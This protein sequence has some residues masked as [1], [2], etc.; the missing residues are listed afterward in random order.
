VSTATQS[1]AVKR[2]LRLDTERRWVACTSA[3]AGRYAPRPPRLIP[4]ELARN[5]AAMGAEDARDPGRTAPLE[6]EHVQ[7]VSRGS[8]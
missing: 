8:G 2:T 6:L 3:N 1:D 5:G 7:R 4:R